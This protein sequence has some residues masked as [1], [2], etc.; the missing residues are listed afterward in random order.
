MKTTS[1]TDH[2]YITDNSLLMDCGLDQ[3]YVGKEW[4]EEGLIVDV[5]YLSCIQDYH[6]T[7]WN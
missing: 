7:L 2:S 5:R 3:N 6:V 4:S 1:S